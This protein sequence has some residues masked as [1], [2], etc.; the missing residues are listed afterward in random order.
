MKALSVTIATLLLGTGLALGQTITVPTTVEGTAG[1]WQWV[2][3]G[4]NTAYQYGIGGNTAPDVVN[5]SSGL[6]FS[7]GFSL[8]IKYV[9]GLVS[10]G[11]GYGWPYTDANG[12]SSIMDTNWYG[13]WAPASF[14]NPSTFPIYAGEM[15]GTFA[16]NSGQI[17]GTPFPVGDLNTVTIPAGATQ[18]QL[19]INSVGYDA[20]VGSW[21]IQVSEIP[22]PT[23]V[24]LVFISLLGFGLVIRRRR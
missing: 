7:P 24:R 18:L 2:N 10:L 6:T 22:E 14:M 17:V 20:D 11:P 21:A 1:P 16:N 5:A 3:G 8:T 15:V 13:G 12:T 9:S 4:L 23:T 19:G